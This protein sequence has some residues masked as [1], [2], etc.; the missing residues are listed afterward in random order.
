MFKFQ[1]K[2]YG[3]I[4]MKPNQ[5][6]LNERRVELP[7]AMEFLNEFQG[8]EILEVGN[9]TRHY[10]PKTEMWHDVVDL[11]EKIEWQNI[12]NEDI[13]SWNPTKKYDAVLSISTLEHTNDPL[14]AVNRILK[15]APHFLI[16]IPFGYSRTH[17]VFEAFPNLLF[18]RRINLEENEWVEATREEVVGTEYN[19][20]FPFANAIMILKI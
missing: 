6:R 8:K 4:D 20:P 9:V 12:M 15:M 2:E 14:L 19:T 7:L 11:Y 3:Y 16:T 10:K 1:G 17:E 5:T 18:M 13:L